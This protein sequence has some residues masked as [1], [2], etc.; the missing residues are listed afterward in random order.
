MLESPVGEESPDLTHVNEVKTE[1]KLVPQEEVNRLIGKVHAKALEKGYKKAMEEMKQQQFAQVPP[2]DNMAQQMP[3]GQPPIQQQQPIY[4]AQDIQQQVQQAILAERQE[5]QR[6]EAINL[7]N[8]MQQRVGQKLAEVQPKYTD[9]NDVM[10]NLNMQNPHHEQVV[11]AVSGLDNAGDVLYEL[12]KNPSKL[13]NVS[14]M[15]DLYRHNPNVA[16]NELNKISQSIKTNE[17][18]QSAPRPPEPL[19]QANPKPTSTGNGE[20]PSVSGMRQYL[21]S[22]RK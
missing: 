22:R 8:Q 6:Q 15:I 12:L 10:Q 21:L 2:Q 13:A 4:N 19:T 9:F 18:A 1:E 11:H 7:A 17:T 3:I 20:L 5:Q 16:L 14:T